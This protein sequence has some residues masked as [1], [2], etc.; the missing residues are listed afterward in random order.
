MPRIDSAKSRIEMGLSRLDIA[1]L[2][3]SFGRAV[4]KANS[5][6]DQKTEWVSE[7]ASISTL[8]PNKSSCQ[9]IP[10]LAP[11]VQPASLC[12]E[13]SNREPRCIQRTLD[14]AFRSTLERLSQL[15]SIRIHDRPEGIR[16]RRRGFEIAD[17]VIPATSRVPRAVQGLKD[18][19]GERSQSPRAMEQKGAQPVTGVIRRLQDHFQR[20]AAECLQP[21]ADV[22]EKSNL[23][24]LSDQLLRLGL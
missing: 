21:E 14:A 11:Q 13:L 18:H 8:E 1:G 19:G 10:P 20:P 5:L 2:K 22:P 15:T 24:F 23:P 12:H 16:L 9:K 6:T 7:K 17:R 3:L 4:R